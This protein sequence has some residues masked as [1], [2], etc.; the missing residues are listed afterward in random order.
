MASYTIQQV[1]TATE[2]RSVGLGTYSGGPKL[3]YTVDSA[4]ITKVYSDEDPAEGSGGV[5]FDVSDGSLSDAYGTPLIYTTVKEVIIY[6]TSV[7][8]S[9][10]VGGGSN[11]LFGTD[12]FIT[13]KAGKCVAIGAVPATVDGSHKILT[14]VPSATASFKILILGS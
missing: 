2:G 8:A 3:T 6:N 7:S 14:L 1:V 12:E 5:M 9:I 11:P 4:T 13:I 10:V